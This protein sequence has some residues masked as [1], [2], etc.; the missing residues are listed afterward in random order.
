MSRSLLRSWLNR[1]ISRRRRQRRAKR[2]VA[3]EALEQRE[4]LSTTLLTEPITLDF[5]TARSPVAPGTRGVAP[6]SYSAA[7]GYGW[8][9]LTGISAV[10]RAASSDPLT[11]DLHKGRN[12]TFLLDVPNGSYQ[13]T[14][15]LGDPRAVMDRVSIYAEGQLVANQLSSSAGSTTQATFNTD[16]TDG[17]LSLQFRDAG[18]VNPYF[19]LAALNIKPLLGAAAGADQ[20]ANEGQAVAFAGQAFSASGSGLSYTWDFGDGTQAIGSLTPSHTYQDNGTYT[21]TLTVTDGSGAAVKDSL[22]VRVNNVAP[23]VTLD[24]SLQGRVNSPF[25]FRA[26]VADPS[27]VDQAAGFIY[28]WDFGNGGTSTDA[29]P[30]HTY[31]AAGTYT[32]NVRV[33]DKDG[34]STTTRTTI[35][36]T[37]DSGSSLAVDAGADQSGR[38]GQALSFQGTAT[39]TA[40]AT[41]VWD[42]GDGTQATGSLTPSHTYR[43]NGVYTVTLTVTDGSGATARDTLRVTVSNVAPTVSAGGPYSANVGAAVS[44]LPSV[45]DPSPVDQAA[46]FTYL[47]NFG[48]GSTSTSRTPSHAYGSAGT[49]TVSLTVTD[50]DGGSSSASTVVMVGQSAGSTL[51]NV[52]NLLALWNFRAANPL[53]NQKAPG[54]YDAYLVGDVPLG[55][56]GAHI[57]GNVDVYHNVN[58]VEAT[59]PASDVP[60]HQGS[61][62]MLVRTD[63]NYDLA[64]FRTVGLGGAVS[65]LESS[66]WSISSLEI[67]QRSDDTG[68]MQAVGHTGFYQ[69]GGASSRPPDEVLSTDPVPGSG[70]W[71]TIG[72]TW[73]EGVGAT[74]YVNGVREGFTATPDP[75]GPFTDWTGGHDAVSYDFGVVQHLSHGGD[76]PWQGNVGAVA[77]SGQV[78]SD[79][80][81]AAFHAWTLGQ[82]QPPPPTGSLTAD[83]GPDQTANEGQAVS[84]TGRATA[85]SSASPLT[86]TWDFGDGTQA[87]GTLTPTHTYRDNGAYTVT[88]TVTDATG[89]S[90]RDTAVVQVSNVAPSVNAGGPY[91][92]VVGSAVAFR[93][94]VTDASPVDQAA[95]FTYLWDFGDGSTSTAASPSHAYAAAGTYTISV[96]VTDKDGGRTTAQTSATV[97]PTTPPAG[98]VVDAGPDQSVSEGQAVSFGG[99]VTAL[100]GRP[101]TGLSYTWDFGDGTQAAGTL[102]PSHTY[103]DNGTYTVTL[104][105]TDGSG[106]TARDTLRVTV[107]NVAPTVSLGG[108]Y[109]IPLGSPVVFTPSVSDPSSVDQAAGFTYLWNFGDGTGSSAANPSHAYGAAGTYT[110]SLTVTDKD[111]GSGTATTTVTVTAVLP[112][113]SLIQTPFDQIPNF[114]LNPT[115]TALNN[116]PWSSP[117]TW[118]LNRLPTAGDIVAIGSGKTVTYDLVSDSALKTIAI[119]SGGTLNFRTDINTRVVVQNFLI[120]EGGTLTIGTPANPVAANVKAEVLI[121]NVPLDPSADP[122]QWGNGLIDLGRVTMYGAAKTS[123]AVRLAAEPHAGDTTLRLAAPVSGWAAGDRLVLPGTPQ[124]EGDT[125]HNSELLTLASVSADG[126]TL[127]LSAPLQYDHLGARG[128]RHNNPVINRLAANHGSDWLATAPVAGDTRN[129]VL[130]FLPHVSNL[131]HNVVIR[132]Q[133]AVGTRGHVVFTNNADVDIHSAQFTGLG[134]TTYSD[135]V[136]DFDQGRYPVQFRHLSDKPTSG[137]R[138][139]FADSSVFCPL[140]QHTFRWG[141]AVQDSRNGVLSGNTLYNWSGSGFVVEDEASRGN[142]IEKNFNVQTNGLPGAGRDNWGQ[143]GEGFAFWG[144]DNTIRD[145]VSADSDAQGFEFYGGG[146]FREFARNEAYGAISGLTMWNING[147]GTT[148]PNPDAPQSTVKDFTAWGVFGWGVGLGYPAFNI[149]FDG[150]V[151]RATP[152]VPAGSN[153][154]Q[155]GDYDTHNFV[156]VNSDIQ[157]MRF[158]IEVPQKT[159]GETIYQPGAV[160]IQDSFLRNEVNLY[161]LT[162]AGPGTGGASSVRQRDTYVRDVRFGDPLSPTSTNIYMEYMVDTQTNNIQI[163]RVWVYDYNGVVGNNLR[164]YYYQQA[165]NAVVPYG[166]PNAGADFYGAPEAGLTNAQA[167]ARW[168]WRLSLDPF[169]VQYRLVGTAGPASNNATPWQ[170]VAVA[171]EVAPSNATDGTAQGIHGLVAPM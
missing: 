146:P 16:V 165:A 60:F 43:D 170:R 157:G 31:T 11:C 67:R 79:A 106:A 34:G 169:Q 117:S 46:G 17:K 4:L 7:R 89:A 62:F 8:Q 101:S 118:S 26:N 120:L 158:G 96:T 48:D 159:N 86:Y 142:L 59:L 108:P 128:A 63:A 52:S 61:F 53:V 3:L 6:V 10:N 21:V 80:D 115:I 49:Y 25:T 155:F 66:T 136:T 40:P 107:S 114:G 154:F 41:Y 112:P 132:S 163:D 64:Q 119:Q 38:E 109:N 144:T 151:V 92:A 24:S 20:S 130:D 76:F 81:A 171:G 102:T 167:Y 74:I 13:I 22:T 29:S 116:G 105:V 93:A 82:G 51:P 162:P 44:F 47:W 37:A 15:I 36:V 138:F 129:D 148:Q 166:D 72:V 137:P 58:Y 50:K 103:Q 84:F 168:E 153:G 2:L 110:V 134:R 131:T 69:L 91:Q 121:A 95:G 143:R 85:G 90:A 9:D 100:G 127:T 125:N 145:N 149:T 14:A 104:T 5:G 18:G 135:P 150:L 28:L 54:T 98:L 32:V 139:I 68:Y 83:A 97:D 12:N 123:G 42:F 126:L 152:G 55:P 39:G 94:N 122:Q 23:Q 35:Q 70:Q 156:I 87:A 75:Y 141:I 71:M 78:W 65:P 1:P 56:D 33:T 73:Q 88:L 30:S 160:T 111:G 27:P 99:S 77:L 133:S 147:A 124:F 161:F 113:G 57:A 45:S 164:V 19:S 140:A